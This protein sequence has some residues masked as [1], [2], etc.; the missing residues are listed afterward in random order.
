[1]HSIWNDKLYQR[2]SQKEKWF[3]LKHQIFIIVSVF[4]LK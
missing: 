4:E 1:M 2:F 3:G